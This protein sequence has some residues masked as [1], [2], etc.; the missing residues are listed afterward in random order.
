MTPSGPD[1]SVIVTKELGFT[2]LGKFPYGEIEVGNF[3][4]NVILPSGNLLDFDLVTLF[5]L[6]QYV[7]RQTYLVVRKGT[8]TIGLVVLARLG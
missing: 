6:T 7:C 4:D 1:K 3:G 2:N 8:G 5:A